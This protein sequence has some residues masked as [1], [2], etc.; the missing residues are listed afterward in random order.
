MLLGMSRNAALGGHAGFA[1]RMASAV[2][3]AFATTQRM[4]DGV[5]CLG[6]GM[7]ANAAMAISTGLAEADVDPIEIAKLADR[8]PA[9]AADAPHFARRQ[10][11]DGP[12]TFFS[13]QS[14][15]AASRADEFA[16]L[17]GVHFD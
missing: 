15:D 10:D 1:D 2:A 16:A 11:D 9:G 6:S 7:R 8:R 13:A 5:H 3:A 12:F 4:V 17:P 14:S